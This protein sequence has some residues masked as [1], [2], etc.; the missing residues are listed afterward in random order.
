MD[1]KSNEDLFISFFIYKSLPD[2]TA[3]LF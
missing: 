1:K 2:N 3:N